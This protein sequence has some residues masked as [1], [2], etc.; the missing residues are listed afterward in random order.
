MREGQG[1]PCKKAGQTRM[2]CPTRNTN[3]EE[4]RD[5]NV[6]AKK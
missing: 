4:G 1:C 5:R 3:P 6:P 2:I